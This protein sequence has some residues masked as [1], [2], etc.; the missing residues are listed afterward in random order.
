MNAGA[1]SLAFCGMKKFL[2]VL[3]LL[4]LAAGVVFFGAQRRAAL[5][6]VVRPVMGPAVQAVYATGT[7]EPAVMLPVAPRI[8]AR[9]VELLGDEGQKV[10]KGEV[11]ARLEDADLQKALEQ[12]QAQAALARKEYN[13]KSALLGQ[14]A[15]SREAAD[16]AEA[17]LKS[18]EARVEEAK[19]TL[20]FMRLEAPDAGIVLRRDGEIGEL[21][22]A[23]KPVF[24]L[25]STAG[26]RVSADVDEEDI[27][28]V[29]PGQ[30]VLIRADAFPDKTFE[31]RVQSITPKGDPVARSYRVRISLPQGT[32]LMIG[33]TAETNI[34]ARETPEAMLLPASAVRQGAVFVV[35]EG[36]AVRR[37][38]ET[39][40]RTK[41][42][43]EIRSGLAPDQAVILDAAREG[44]EELRLRPRLRD[45]KAP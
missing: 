2:A 39:G 35:E 21:I 18:A 11:L 42:A 26:L 13:R 24:W 31:G 8:S 22:P 29:E 16:Q 14:N 36:R 28:L 5:T 19:A 12:A 45:W 1:F 41:E 9:L 20:G 3:V 30:K 25:S 38:V 27:S 10:A 4:A 23:N 34:I 37:P 7:V 43:V 33:M 44:L 40:A 15:I 6:D 32:P 17:A